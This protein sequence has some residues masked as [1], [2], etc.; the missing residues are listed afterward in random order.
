MI[1]PITPEQMNKLYSNPLLAEQMGIAKIY[2]SANLE[3][4][5]LDI[6]KVALNC[7]EQNVSCYIAGSIGSGKTHL[8]AAMM[9]E[10]IK[11][12]G[13]FDSDKRQ[14]IFDAPRMIVSAELFMKQRE[15]ISNSQ[16]EWRFLKAICEKS[17]LVIDDIGTEKPTEA[18]RELLHV[19]IN[20]R[21]SDG[22]PFIITGNLDL[23][24][25]G[26]L[27]DDRIASRIAGAGIQIKVEGKDR[28]LQEHT[29]NKNKTKGK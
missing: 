21:Y 15:V 23:N 7:I 14:Y 19:I 17:F 6:S 24:G 29:I 10:W 5:S 9:Y 13:K 22:K 18:K 27:Y 25:L 28:R 3:Q 12:K 8:A 1:E 20:R 16:S 4:F 26:E 11:R 2:I